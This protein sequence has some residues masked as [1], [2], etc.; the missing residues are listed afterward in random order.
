MKQQDP[1]VKQRKKAKKKKKIILYSAVGGAALFLIGLFFFVQYIIEGLP[2]LEQLENPTPQLASNVYSSEGVLIGQF[3][4]QNRIEADLDSIPTSF[5]DAL[6]ATEDRKFFDHWGVDLDRFIKAMIKNVFLF[7]REGAS[8]ITQQ[9]AKNLY[10]LKTIDE[11]LYDT[12]VRKI[13]EWITAIQIERTY[14]KDEIL[15]MYFNIS[16][17]GRS[18]YGIA[19]AS[20]VYF[21]KDVEDLTI[22][23]TS[24]LIAL[25]KS[26]LYYDPIRNYNNSVRRRNLVMYNM[27]QV[28]FLDKNTYEEY[29]SLP[30]KVST[31]RITNAFRSTFAPH[32]VE[33]VR[34]QLSRMADEYGFNLYEDGLQIYTTLDTTMQKIANRAV[35][36]HLAEFQKQFDGYWKWS[37]HRK[38]LDD[39][40]EKAIRERQD[41]QAAATSEEKEVVLERLKNNVAFMDSIQNVAQTI[42]VG[43]VA[44][45]VKTGE[46]KAMVGGINQDFK[47]GLNHVTQIK[48][49]P[50][51]AF[52]PIIYSVA[53]ESGLYPAY[54]ILN[55][56]F[57]Y[58]GW[59]PNNFD[60][61]VGGFVTL[62]EA[63]RESLN[64]VSARLIIE[65]HVQLW[66][67]GRVASDL[68]IKSKLDLVPSI[69]LGAAEVTPLELTNVYATLANEGIYNEPIAITKIEDNDGILID[70]FY[71]DSREAIDEETA[72]IMTNMLQTVVDEGTGQRIRL[73]HN[74]HRPAA[75]KTG[76]TQD[77]GDAWFVGYTP[78]IAAGVWVGFDDRRIS[79]TGSYGQGSKAA[80]PI[81]ANF[82]REVYEQKDLPLEDFNMP[83]SGDI[84]KADFCKET[85]FELGDPKLYSPDCPG[86]VFTDF[87]KVNDIPDSYDPE[88]DTEIKIFEKYMVQDSVSNEAIEII[89]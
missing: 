46:I 34:Q 26:P 45:D 17:F 6:I 36:E 69:S 52:K 54:P 79:F 66:K 49:Q 8:T 70:A 61:S 75:G 20:N 13:R 87:I 57:D 12:I 22:P 81:W 55:Q 84:V 9:L 71:S 47:Y 23:E 41:Y 37:K 88:R 2:S 64:L 63:L 65:D 48:R 30:I 43:F 11:S 24:V 40:V 33:Y 80:I 86:D 27:V 31:D 74:F 15:E 50:G 68:G 62:R 60:H 42:E 76:T 14:T 85:I 72:F 10:E 19:T 18:A 1:K 38:L 7:K 89:D 16:Y 51:S 3:F 59:S 5:V 58:R 67:V 77:Y 82:M 21:D 73:I 28:G 56:P 39:I 4:K 78:Q 83:P 35:E 29:K 44:L 32:Y 25:L 53:L